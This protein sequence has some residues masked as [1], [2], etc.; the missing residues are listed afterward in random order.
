MYIDNL[1]SFLVS[2]QQLAVESIMDIVHQ[3]ISGLVNVVNTVTNQK[4]SLSV[5]ERPPV[6]ETSYYTA[7]AP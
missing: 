3:L 1:T 7:D 6:S 4:D 2:K 5:V